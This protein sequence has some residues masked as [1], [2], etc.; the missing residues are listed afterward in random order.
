MARMKETAG[1]NILWVS[2][3][4]MI[5]TVF[6]DPDPLQDLCVADMATGTVKVNGFICKESSKVNASDFKFSGLAKEGSTNNSVGS[7]VTA[8]NVLKFAGLN[9]LGISMGR[10]DFAPGGVNPPH[11]HP[12]ATE[13]IFVLKG[14]LEVGFIT[15]SNMLYSQIVKKGDVFVF[16]KALVHFQRNV[17]KG[18]AAVLTAFN[19][20]LPGTQ[21]IPVTLFGSTPPI[22][23]AVLS[24]A[25][26]IDGGEVEK[27]K[28]NFK[29][30]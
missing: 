5:L 28:S 27:I 13:I 4:L 22:D 19:S 9:T 20:Q 16:P 30:K 14:S 3:T 18:K 10:A 8:A 17:G 24:K 15:T 12:R 6:A 7:N 29:P 25:F 1:L 26:H 21:S 11:T 23:D 2:L